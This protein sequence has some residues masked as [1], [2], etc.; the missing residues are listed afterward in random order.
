VI[1]GWARDLSESGLGAFV[2]QALELGE[3]VTLDIPVAAAESVA[4]EA[5]VVR[6]LGT[7]YG[8]Q[9][10]TLSPTQRSQIRDAVKGRT[11]LL[12]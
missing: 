6:C 11:K 8:F 1:E 3:I 10:I 2:G 7:E 5:E 9:F 4:V 12:T